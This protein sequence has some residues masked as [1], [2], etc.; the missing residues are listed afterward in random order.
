MGDCQRCKSNFTS[1]QNLEQ[2]KL[3]V[4][5]KLVHKCGIC[6][7]VFYDKSTLN[8][9]INSSTHLKKASGNITAS[10]DNN[11]RVMINSNVHSNNIYILNFNEED[12]NC[13]STKQI[14]EIIKKHKDNVGIIIDYLEIVNFNKKFPE[15]HNIYVSNKKT[16]DINVKENDN[17]ILKDKSFSKEIIIEVLLFIQYEYNKSKDS[18]DRNTQIKFEKMAEYIDYTDNELSDDKKF[19]RYNREIVNFLYNNREIVID[20]LSI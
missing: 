7:K 8:K 1:K 11:S 16:K 17:W 18:L 3:E 10:A 5:C 13:I 2:H 19:R 4:N 6:N 12:P 20:L 15:N 9:H 14:I